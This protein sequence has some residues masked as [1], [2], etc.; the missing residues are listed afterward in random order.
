M[1]VCNPALALSASQLIVSTISKRQVCQLVCMGLQSGA[2]HW[3][4]SLNSFPTLN[5]PRVEVEL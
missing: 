3:T 5:T 4:L 1:N 2:F